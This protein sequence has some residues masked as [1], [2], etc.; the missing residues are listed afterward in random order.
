M[1]LSAARY[2]R[3]VCSRAIWLGALLF[4]FLAV[5][6]A[7][8]TAAPVEQRPF[9]MV[10][11]PDTQYYSQKWPDLFFA[12][13]N[14][15]KQN[16][17]K[18]N[19]VFVMHLGDLVQNHSRQPSE[20]KVADEAMAVLDGV[21]P[22]GIAIGNHD[23]DSKEGLKKALATTYLRHFDPEKRFKGQPGYGGASPN[24]LNSCHLV[25][26]GGVDFAILFLEMNPSDDALEWA[27][28]VLAR[29]RDR[30][31][32]VVMHSYLLGL[33][34][35]GR[36]SRHR[37]GGN[38]G[39]MVWDKFVCSQPRV[40]MVV[41]GHVGRAD[42]YHQISRNDAG[43]QVL[44]MLCDYQGREKGGNGWLRIMRF[45]PAKRE[46]QMRTYTPVLDRF[47]TDANSEFVVPWEMN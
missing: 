14:W 19:I 8:P 11:L 5:G 18:E 7:R 9:S 4:L 34:G 6:C 22:Y 25:S 33:D 45:V 42:E 17:E 15:I 24:R 36:D 29:H 30:W 46:I 37:E 2:P 3:H 32:I 10:V 41:C 26:A 13:T 43:A 35:I 23:Y 47:E 44:E 27:K 28:G 16:R 20:W 21:V 40:F 31:A 39:E 38:S 12:Q 1:S